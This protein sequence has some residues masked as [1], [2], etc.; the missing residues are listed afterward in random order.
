MERSQQVV[1]VTTG[2]AVWVLCT[3]LLTG[4][5]AIWRLG[6]V[7]GRAILFC[8]VLQ[9]LAQCQIWYHLD[10]WSVAPIHLL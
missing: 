5:S 7:T 2:F 8:S 6:N 4:I 3:S 10:V 1:A 9:L